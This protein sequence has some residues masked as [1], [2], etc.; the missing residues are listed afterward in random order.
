M[1][2]QFKTKKN[3]IIPILHCDGA[4]SELLNDIHDIGFEVFNLPFDILVIVILKQFTL[5]FGIGL[6]KNSMK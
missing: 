4:V 5:F 2:D 3:D 6:H 1:I